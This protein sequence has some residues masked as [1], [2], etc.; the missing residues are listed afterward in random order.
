VCKQKYENMFCAVGIEIQ[1]IFCAVAVSQLFIIFRLPVNKQ[2]C[3]VVWFVLKSRFR[4]RL[5]EVSAVVIVLPITF[6][7]AHW[8][9]F[10]AAT[11][12]VGKR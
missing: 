5:L 7:F 3:Q 8:C 4:V 12:R 9:D 2:R 6:V 10:E 1:L 11:V